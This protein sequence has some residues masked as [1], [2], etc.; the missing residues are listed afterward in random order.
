MSLKKI[1]DFTKK[2]TGRHL[3]IASIITSVLLLIGIPLLPFIPLVLAFLGYRKGTKKLG[4]LSML[5]SIVILALFV[6]YYQE[7]INFNS[8]TLKKQYAYM[9]IPNTFDDMTYNIA[10]GN[11]VGWYSNEENIEKYKYELCILGYRYRPTESPLHII[12]SGLAIIKQPWY[13]Y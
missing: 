9:G 13:V 1:S 8:F 12:C 2:V 3:I 10:V 5:L 6:G 4:I 7:D 11:F